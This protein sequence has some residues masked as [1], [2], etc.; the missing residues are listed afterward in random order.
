LVQA[1][2]IL[3]KSLLLPVI[4]FNFNFPTEPTIKDDLGPYLNDYNNRSLQA[5]S[6]IATRNFSSG[7]GQNGTLGNQVLNTA[8]T[9]ATELVFNRL[10]TIISQSNAIHNLD[11]NIR[12]FNDASASLRLFNER[13]V[14]TGTLYNNSGNYQIYNSSSTLFNTNF[15]SLSKDFSA[16]YLILKNG[17][18][19]A[20]YSYRLLNTTI[21]NQADLAGVQYVNGLGL[22]Y[23]RDFDTFGEFLR[24][25]FSN[26]NRKKPVNPLPVPTNTPSTPPPSNTSGDSGAKG[27][28][29]EDN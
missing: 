3:T 12:S 24:N 8:G 29:E 9:A 16:Q 1:E 21:L 6:L 19:N 15:T 18:L 11:L 26:G 4:D 14:L 5:I 7:T 25:I 22:V 2:L 28:D 20:R 17:S 10:N 27:S 13:F 23:Q